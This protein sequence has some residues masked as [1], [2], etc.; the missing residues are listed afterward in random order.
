MNCSKALADWEVL[1]AAEG[2]MK[3]TILYQNRTHIRDQVIALIINTLSHGYD[4]STGDINHPMFL[5]R[6]AWPDRNVLD[7]MPT[8]FQCEEMEFKEGSLRTLRVQVIDVEAFV[9]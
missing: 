3:F 1:V 5:S 2:N 4:L 6:P 7:S 9:D 8:H